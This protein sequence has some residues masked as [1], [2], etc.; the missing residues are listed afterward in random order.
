MHIAEHYFTGQN[1]IDLYDTNHNAMLQ[2][3]DRCI[4]ET[5]RK[6]TYVR[7]GGAEASQWG[8]AFISFTVAPCIKPKSAIR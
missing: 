3:S 8:Y 4:R 1:K 7:G 5:K 6:S 2:E